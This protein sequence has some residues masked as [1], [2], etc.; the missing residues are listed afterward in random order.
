[1]VSR[2]KS[3]LQSRNVTVG[4]HRT[5]LRLEQDVWDA[6]E[7]ICSRE[8]LNVHELC[9]HIE[10]HRDVSSRTASVRTYVLSYFRA[11]A[12]DTGHVRAGHGTLGQNKTRS[13]DGMKKG[14]P[15]Q[16]ER[17]FY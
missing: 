3:R 15:T 2:I 14:R 17:N 7:E 12:S 4:G 1:L 6:L 9:T 8:S 5:S 10:K 11:A 13:V 16:S